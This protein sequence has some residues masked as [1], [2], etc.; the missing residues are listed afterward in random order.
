MIG[1]L[2]D[3]GDYESSRLCSVLLKAA[4]STPQ[5]KGDSP[6]APV[7]GSLKLSLKSFVNTKVKRK[8]FAAQKRTLFGEH[9]SLFNFCLDKEYLLVGI[10]RHADFKKASM[11]FTYCCPEEN[12]LPEPGDRLILVR[13]VGKT[14]DQIEADFATFCPLYS[15]TI[16]K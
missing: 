14:N 6:V 8:S 10:Y 1:Q 11:P 9:K 15:G 3:G 12:T 16:M 7:K 5:D 13:P 4:E 2:K